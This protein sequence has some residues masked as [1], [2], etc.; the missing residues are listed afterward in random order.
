MLN[1]S[2][3]TILQD[4]RRL[5]AYH[6]TLGIQNYPTTPGLAHFLHPRPGSPPP[7]RWKRKGN[8]LPP[9]SI[10]TPSLADIREEMEGCS[11]CRL[12]DSRTHIVFGQGCGQPDVLIV[13]EWPS[14]EDDRQAEAFCGPAGELLTKM[15]AAINLTRDE[16]FLTY[17]VKCLPPANRA[18]TADEINTC[19]NF[20]HRQIEIM[21]P[22]VICTMGP[23]AASTLLR[24]ADSLF[25]LRGRFHD[26]QT[27]QG[28]IVPLLPTFHPA[29][30]IKNPEMKK[31]SWHDL[32]L[33]QK[34]IAILQPRTK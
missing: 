20:L 16:V 2:T 13:A 22:R 11:S 14:G 10:V 9:R 3:V 18:P 30:L 19:L 8:S 27:A 5:L 33:L 17:A 12:C 28:E 15:L 23:L 21:Q 29:F 32:Q 25:R 31:A 26:F 7:G 4:I 6:L 34:K 1:K 24:S